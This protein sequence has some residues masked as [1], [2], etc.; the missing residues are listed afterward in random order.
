MR[1]VRKG[2]G[3]RSSIGTEVRGNRVLDVGDEAEESSEGADLVLECFTQ[4]SLD[5]L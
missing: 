1:D 2:R 3:Q 5:C 4:R